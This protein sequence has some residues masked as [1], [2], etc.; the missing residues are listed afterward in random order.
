MFT[1]LGLV[2]VMIEIAFWVLLLLFG[3]SAYRRL[4][5]PSLPWLGMFFAIGLA[6][7]FI[8]PLAMPQAFRNFQRLVVPPFGWDAGRFILWTSYFSAIFE[9]IASLIVLILVAS[10][11]VFVMRDLEVMRQFRPWQLLLAVRRN[12]KVLGFTLVVLALVV[13]MPVLALVIFRTAEA[14]YAA[15][16]L[17]V[18]IVVSLLAICVFCWRRSFPE[19]PCLHCEYDLQGTIAAGRNECPECGVAILQEA[20]T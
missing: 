7:R 13:P 14:A 19:H 4:K 18:V 2:V 9:R 10:E 11:I 20:A 5:P 1:T 17:W 8:L 15:Y 3:I 12:A 6:N 16:G